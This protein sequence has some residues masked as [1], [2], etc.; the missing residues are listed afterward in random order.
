MD[1]LTYQPIGWKVWLTDWYFWSTD[2]FSKI[3]KKTKCL[4]RLTGPACVLKLRLQSLQSIIFFNIL[5]L[6]TYYL[7]RGG[8]VWLKR[9][10]DWDGLSGWHAS[11]YLLPGLGL[12]EVVS[13]SAPE[14]RENYEEM[15]TEQKRVYSQCWETIL[16][17]HFHFVSINLFLNGF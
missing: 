4:N 14:C 10:G 7:G 11:A 15:I 12:L 1:V 2:R 9:W 17:E 5:Y 13:L 6:L 16:E 3:V 8:G